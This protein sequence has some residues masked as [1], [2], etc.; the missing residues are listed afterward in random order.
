MPTEIVS[1]FVRPVPKGD[2]YQQRLAQELRLIEN[3]GLTDLFVQVREI[4]D[5]IPDIPRNIRGSA[6]S[7][8]VCYL[9]GITDIDPLAWGLG[10]ARFLHDLRPDMPD[11]DIDL[12][13]NRRAE[14]WERVFRRYGT[15]A[16]RVSNRVRWR[17]KSALREARRVL[18]A[19]ATESELQDYAKD[20]LGKQRHWSLHC[21]GLVLSADDF[22]PSDLLSPH[23]VAWDKEDVEAK[24]KYKIDL[25]SS[26]GLGQLVQMD[27]R[28][29]SEYPDEDQGAADVWRR[30]DTLGI[31]GGESPAFLKASLGLK[32]ANKLDIILASALI[33]PAAASGTRSVPFFD[34]WVARREQTALV[35]DDDCIAAIAERCGKTPA[36]ADMMRRQIVKG[37]IPVPDALADIG[38]FT[39]YSFCKSHAVAYGSLVWALSYHKARNPVAFWNAA[40]DNCVSM[41]RRWVHTREAVRVGINRQLQSYMFAPSPWESYLRDGVWWQS[42]DLPGLSE[43]QQGGVLRFRALI[44]AYRVYNPRLG[45]KKPITFV[46]VWTGKR[47]RQLV[48]DGADY[49]LR[50]APVIEGFGAVEVVQRAE[51]VRVKGYNLVSFGQ[52]AEIEKKMLVTFDTRGALKYKE[53]G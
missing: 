35:Y 50:N 27:D 41:Y 12:P 6:G 42:E 2:G 1:R 52:S 34:T 32:A 44:G 24:G 31:T 40:L 38:E 17:P 43:H 39:A 47:Y 19:T 5:L 28:P 49:W 21:G 26:R 11:I 7:S 33:R 30:G 18:G 25:L 45:G 4:L 22:N 20:L 46:T 13:W 48:L 15:K 23:Q 29:L 10:L 53:S 8:L 9:L 14:V 51:H 3:H 16:A 37:R 36:E